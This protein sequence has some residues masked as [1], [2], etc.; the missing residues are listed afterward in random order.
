MGGWVGVLRGL[1]GVGEDIAK[2][3]IA[4]EDREVKRAE[5]IERIKREQAQTEEISQRTKQPIVIGTRPDGRVVVLD[6]KDN[7][8]KVITP[9]G[10]Q[11][12]FPKGLSPQEVHEWAQSIPDEHQKR[13]YE[14]IINLQ[15]QEGNYKGA[16]DAMTQ[17]AERF[18]PQ[19]ASRIGEPQ[20]LDRY[21]ASLGK[22][23]DELT[24]SEYLEGHRKWAKAGHIAAGDGGGAVSIADEAASIVAGDAKLSDYPIKGRAS[25]ANY[26]RIH[27][28]KAPA[29]LSPTEQRKL[30]AMNDVEPMLD[31]L[32]GTLESAELTKDNNPIG[33]RKAWLEYKWLKVLPSDP[34]RSPL[35]KDSAA[36][37]IMGATPW[38]T[39]G[40]GK[41]LFDT[42]SQHLP[43]PEDTPALLYDK[44]KWLK[45]ELIAPQ[46]ERIERQAK[47]SMG[48]LGGD[49]ES[50]TTDID[51]TVNDI[52]KR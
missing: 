18:K 27:K 40:R 23:V 47:G 24:P 20:F 41:Y 11:A 36:L 28:M 29:K 2:G 26:M 43:N 51:K 35:I 50:P 4:A 3:K 22:K 21:A 45:E 42:I 46:R 31:R 15:V 34:I 25:I 37:Q 44:V 14:S 10:L 49:L 9:P 33:P 52:L 7:Q 17:A 48:D 13:L 8:I 19:S 30:D 5:T 39:I 38:I 1:G 16:L 32:I 12:G 6:P